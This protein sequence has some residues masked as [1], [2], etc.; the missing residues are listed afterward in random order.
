MNLGEIFV[1]E[2]K[3]PSK[4]S[5]IQIQDLWTSNFAELDA[6]QFINLI[7]SLKG[8]EIFVV[9][10]LLHNGHHLRN[11]YFGVQKENVWFCTD[12]SY[13]GDF[14]T[15]NKN[16]N[17]FKSSSGEYSNFKEFNY[18]HLFEC[19]NEK[20]LKEFENNRYYSQQYKLD[21]DEL[22]KKF[23]AF[24][25]NQESDIYKNKYISN[26]TLERLL[27]NIRPE[28]YNYQREQ[29]QSKWLKIH[30]FLMNNSG[31][32]IAKIAPAG[33]KAKQTDTTTS[34]LDISFCLNEDKTRE[35]IY[36]NLLNQ[37]KQLDS[38][39]LRLSIGPHAIHIDFPNDISID[40]VLY[41]KS[42]FEEK[43]RETQFIRNMEPIYHD[44]IRLIKYTFEVAK[45]RGIPGI[46]IEKK[47][48]MM[49]LAD[50]ESIYINVC[51]INALN[52]FDDDLK[53]R[54]KEI[55]DI[56]SELKNN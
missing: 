4:S 3:N 38:Y 55:K 31:L 28:G 42:E 24:K 11:D 5:H 6:E 10:K 45:I 17:L 25:R 39:G 2:Q 52:L 9:K 47:I 19:D 48:L 51:F 33:S 23:K 18:G 54:G 36:P 22:K 26:E 29:Y 37:L 44:L 53:K 32:T 21:F 30:N 14:E 7:V 40:I 41:T 56:I 50:C 15:F 16:F 43:Y 20:D 8:P 13:C 49:E 34:D 46:E 12:M 35:E 27:R 1:V